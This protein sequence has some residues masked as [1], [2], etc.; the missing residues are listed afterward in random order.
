MFGLGHVWYG[1]VGFVFAVPLVVSVS[2]GDVYSLGNDCLRVCVLCGGQCVWRVSILI[3]VLSWEIRGLLGC[4]GLVVW[5]GTRFLDGV[6][7]MSGDGETCLSGA[8]S[9][10]M[11]S[12]GNGLFP[13]WVRIGMV[14]K[15]VSGNGG[16]RPV[17][18]LVSN[19][20][21][22]WYRRGNLVKCVRVRVGF[23]GFS[24]Q[25]LPRS[26]MY[27]YCAIQ[28]GGHFL[29]RNWMT[30]SCQVSARIWGL[31]GACVDIYEVWFDVWECPG[32]FQPVP[33]VDRV[34]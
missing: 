10:V 3:W 27:T 30:F 8:V 29:D 21:V 22:D 1:F 20:G 23:R 2:I 26:L 33:G 19:Q 11:F 9:E 18:W 28:N 13:A 15:L 14:R 4:V 12:S 16:Y 6:D 31:F 34:C 17:T 24:V 5:D 25:I 32:S 7:R